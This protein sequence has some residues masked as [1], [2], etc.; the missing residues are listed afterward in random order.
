MSDSKDS[1]E[2]I[3]DQIL[4]AWSARA[5]GIA[6]ADLSDRVLKRVME[7][8]PLRSSHAGWVIAFA[9]LAFGLVSA[10]WWLTTAERFHPSD[11]SRSD[12]LALQ[13]PIVPTAEPL[14]SVD[15]LLAEVSLFQQRLQL[16]ELESQIGRTKRRLQEIQSR[17]IRRHA[18]DLAIHAWTIAQNQP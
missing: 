11:R 12:V 3:S 9:S 10:L 16:L 4:N 13:D 2:D 5:E 14:P 15:A 1:L 6:P 8:R 17:A 7:P 18:R